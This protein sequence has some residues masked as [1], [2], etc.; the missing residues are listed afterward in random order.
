MDDGRSGRRSYA[1]HLK[2]NTCSMSVLGQRI[3]LVFT[4]QQTRAYRG[5]KGPLYPRCREEASPSRVYTGH[6]VAASTE[7]QRERSLDGTMYMILAV[8]SLTV[9]SH[10]LSRWDQTTSGPRGRVGH[11]APVRDAPLVSV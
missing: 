2:P 6:P 9:L 1:P 3:C 5:I 4:K 11:C 7:S 8:W 10:E